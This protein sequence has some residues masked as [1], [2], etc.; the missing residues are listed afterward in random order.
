MCKCINRAITLH[1]PRR[2]VKKKKSRFYY[3][4]IDINTILHLLL[5]TATANK[6]INKKLPAR[7][8]RSG[9]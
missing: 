4:Y 9:G 3:S 7:P 6:L 8:C 2:F 1:L 5:P